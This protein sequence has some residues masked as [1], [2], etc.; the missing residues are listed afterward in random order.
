[1]RAAFVRTNSPRRARELAPWASTVRKVES[2]YVLF[3]S[4]ADAATVAESSSR[5][6]G[7]TIVYGILRERLQAYLTETD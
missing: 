3:E 1:M 6:D 7:P 5:L 2:G 4:D